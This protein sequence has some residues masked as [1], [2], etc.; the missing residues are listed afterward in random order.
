MHPPKP[1]TPQQVDAVLA[2]ARVLVAVVARSVAAVEDVVSLP[3]LRV[4]VMVSTSGP[5]NLSAV[6]EG[7][8]VHASNATR[9]CDRLVTAGLLDRRD[10]EDDRRH[11][12]LTLTDE[13]RQLVQ[14]VIEH[15]RSAIERVLAGMPAALRDGLAGDLQAFAA[16]AGEVPDAPGWTLG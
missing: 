12:A 3:Q 16:A 13:G 5:L 8:G 10:A 14:S 1:A 6:A 7:L 9:T 4:L 2:A 15:R 11:V